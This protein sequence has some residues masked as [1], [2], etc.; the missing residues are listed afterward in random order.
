MDYIYNKKQNDEYYKRIEN[1]VYIQQH[2]HN[3]LIYEYDT[4]SRVYVTQQIYFNEQ[5]GSFKNYICYAGVDQIFINFNGDIAPCDD[6]YETGVNIGNIYD[7]NF[8]KSKFHYRICPL[9]ICPCPF[10]SKKQKIMHNMRF[11]KIK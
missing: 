6:L 8:D 4:Y 10:F 7:N 2:L 3:S 1:E 5:L 9:K 11:N